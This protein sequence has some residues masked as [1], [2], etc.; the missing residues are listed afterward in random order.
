MTA[1][2]LDLVSGMFSACDPVVFLCAFVGVMVGTA[3]GFIPGLGP[4]IGIAVAIP[5]TYGFEPLAAIGLLMGL[6]KGGTYG[7]SISA[8][9]INTPGTA[10]ATATLLD[11]YPLAQQGRAGKALKCALFGSCIGDA[12]AIMLLIVIAQPIASIALK[13][14]P[15]ELFS[16]V[17]FALA[18]VSSLAAENLFKGLMACALGLMLATVGMDP[19]TG[20]YRFTFGFQYLTD[21]FSIIAMAIGLFALA[22][23]LNQSQEK[24]VSCEQA[25]LPP[26]ATKDDTRMTRGDWKRCLPVFFQSSAIGAAIGALPGTGS[27]LAAYM[28]YGNAKRRSKYPDLFGKGNIEGVAASEAGNNAV[29]GGALIPMLTLGV[30]GDAVT[31]ILMSALLLHGVTVG[32]MVFVEHRAF[33]F[34]LFGILLISILMLLISGFFF[35]WV[36]NKLCRLSAAMVMPVVVMLCA[37][38][39]YASNYNMYDVGAIIGFAVL[40]FTMMKLGLPVAPMLISFVLQ[41]SIESNLRQALLVSH[42]DVS[43]FFTKPISAAFLLLA[44]LVILQ[45]ARS[46]V[47]KARRQEAAEQ[48]AA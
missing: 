22:E 40:G 4:A 34:G 45:V 32:P 18:V 38:G 25:L 12:F 29:C 35:I 31:A 44:A 20:D 14:G 10:A 37:M 5:V 36:G 8:I 2:F 21:G 30:P 41:P 3:F 47:K 16:L 42:G 43:I 15:A 13:F 7:G 46:A 39:A 33:T 17:I 19:I 26:P 27:V 1:W 24:V 9:L 28:S 6:Y 48:A 23:V 11:G